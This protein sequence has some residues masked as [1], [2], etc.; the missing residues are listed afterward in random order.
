MSQMNNE[1]HIDRYVR[2]TNR[3]R[4]LIVRALSLLEHSCET[5]GFAYDGLNTTPELMELYRISDVFCEENWLIG[6]NINNDKVKRIPTPED[7]QEGGRNG[8]DHAD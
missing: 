5:L 8:T 6:H 3:E 7:Y 4:F 2:I 1:S